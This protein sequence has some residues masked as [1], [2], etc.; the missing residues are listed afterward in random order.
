MKPTRSTESMSK[1]KRRLKPATLVAALALWAGGAHAAIIG[2]YTTDSAFTAA[3]SGSTLE[4]F[5][6][7]IS[8]VA[9]G[10]RT[11]YDYGPFLIDKYST[12]GS[13]SRV[14][15]WQGRPTATLPDVIIFDDLL[16]AWGGFINTDIG[17][18]GVGIQLTVELLA[19]NQVV[20]TVGAGT[21]PNNGFLGFLSSAAFN[22]VRLTSVGS[23]ADNYTLDNMRYKVASQSV[24]EPASLALLGA[25]LLGMAVATRRRRG[26]G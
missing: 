26:R 10:A 13:G 1:L 23:G 2:T 25:G 4:S 14:G 3:V 8:G 7:Q 24:P 12:G 15:D 16:T 21:D 18:N 22:T 20:G 9:N 6:T 11:T 19:G 17:G 5:S